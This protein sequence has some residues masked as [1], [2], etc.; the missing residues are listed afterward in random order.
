MSNEAKTIL[1]LARALFS[2]PPAVV[3]AWVHGDEAQ[4]Y[5]EEKARQLQRSPFR[6][7]GELEPPQLERLTALAW[8]APDPK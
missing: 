6:W 1:H 8:S 5:L 7:I 2:T 4:G 3:V